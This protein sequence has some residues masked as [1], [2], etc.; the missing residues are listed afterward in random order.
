MT[1]NKANA[2]YG[3]FWALVCTVASYY[4]YER[5]KL[6]SLDFSRLF[7][8][9]YVIVFGEPINDFHLENGLTLL[10][11]FAAIISLGMMIYLFSGINGKE[12]IG[13]KQPVQKRG[14]KPKS[15]ED[16][17]F[18]LA[19]NEGDVQ[20]K[21]VDSP[22]SAS[23]IHNISHTSKA[24]SSEASEGE[25]SEKESE[26]RHKGE[27][28]KRLR[29]NVLVEK[30][31][32]GDKIRDW[33]YSIVISIT[34][35]SNTVKENKE[36]ALKREA[37]F[38]EEEINN[39]DI[40]PPTVISE[41]QYEIHV[42]IISDRER[43]NNE[44]KFKY[45]TVINQPKEEA[46][47]PE[48][49]ESSTETSKEENDS[50]VNSESSANE[51]S[52]EKDAEYNSE[53]F[54]SE[55]VY[56]PSIDE[57]TEFDTDDC[58]DF[59]KS[60][61]EEP[62]ATAPPEEEKEEI[63]EYVEQRIDGLYNQISD[64]LAEKYQRLDEVFDQIRDIREKLNITSIESEKAAQSDIEGDPEYLMMKDLEQTARTIVDEVRDEERKEAKMQF[65]ST[66]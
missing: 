2:Y 13:R 16:H 55:P 47:Q 33:Y 60:S 1:G 36:K 49:L 64:I 15:R 57:E 53:L 63:K 8:S 21:T 59:F 14:G 19:S 28:N 61:E 54:D 26:T 31:T 12:G 18:L 5:F 11:F 48:Q 44:Y 42:G 41:K 34:D 17:N 32:L 35:G 40:A 56:G 23:N 62:E 46:P 7:K 27:D 20:M 43:E 3:S 38:S 58:K 52:E 10:F 22:V 51:F 24:K 65:K 9:A 4:F 30:R 50:S 45:G 25:K 37:G 39:P 66:A 29:K 6:I